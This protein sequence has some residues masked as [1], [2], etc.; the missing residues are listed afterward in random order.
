MRKISVLPLAFLL[1]AGIA[2]STTPTSAQKGAEPEYGGRPPMFTPGPIE[3]PFTYETPVP[4]GPIPPKGEGSF[5]PVSMFGMNLYLSG[6]ERTGMEPNQIASLA[7]AGGV[8]WSREE[9]AWA[10]LEPNTKGEFNWAPFDSRLASNFNNNINV[11]GMLLTTPRWASTNPNAGDWYWYEPAN[12]NDYFDFVRAAVNHWKNNIHTWEIWNEPNH[13]ATWNCLNNCDRAA[14]YAQLLSGAYAAVKSVDPTAR[15]L[16]GGL[17]VHDTNNEG[18]SFL[19]SVIANSGGAINFDGMSIH[20]YMPDRVPESLDPNTLVQNFQYRLNMVNDWINA[21][22]GNPSEIWITEEGKSTCTVSG[23]CPANMTWSEDA[24]ASM[25]TRMYGI[26]AASPR[27]V[28]FSYFQAEDKFNNPANLY[29]G[30]SVLY[31]NYATKQ[32]Y[33]AYRTA[34]AQLDGATYAG[35]GPQ[36][37]P[38]NNPHQPDTSDYVGFD[39]KFTRGGQNINLVWRVSGTANVN[40]PVPGTSV[41]VIDRDGNVTHMTPSGGTIPITISARPQYIVTSACTAR[42]SD[43]CPDFWAYTYIECLAS[44]QIISGYS[45]GTFKPNNPITRAQLAKVVSN[46]AGFNDNPTGQTFQDIPIG[47]TFYLFVER[48]AGRGIVGGYAC[49]GPGEPCSGGNRPY[50]RPNA[51]TTRGQI[52][53]I[54]SEAKGYNDTPTGQ[55]FQDVPPAS[56]FYTW[57]QRLASRGFMSGYACGGAGE[58]CGGGNL[59]YFRPANNGSR[60]QVSK[61]VANAFFPECQP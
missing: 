61:I 40:Y 49:G 12:Y 30:M 52:S 8:K 20:T 33:F 47:S 19:N 4:A 39:Y 27:V 51:N 21:H 32:A 31:D 14:R 37:I 55:S 58:P 46:S 11:I 38:G 44:R 18:M 5:P 10:N 13:Q 2:I 29:G 59:P 53:K 56:T 42:F 22:G 34:S 36:M 48:L 15:V 7:V 6:L 9:L 3:G 54:V 41:D 17:Y 50:F 28:H 23:S 57:V 16:I 60:A 43:V 26:A 45:D 25:L 1:L 24:Q 35:M